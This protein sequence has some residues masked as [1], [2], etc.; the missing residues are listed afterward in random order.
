MVTFCDIYG[1]VN[2]LT[3]KNIVSLIVN[4]LSSLERDILKIQYF[5]DDDISMRAEADKATTN[6]QQAVKNAS[7]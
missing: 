6:I 1:D 5:T 2:D 4:L 7:E 3:L